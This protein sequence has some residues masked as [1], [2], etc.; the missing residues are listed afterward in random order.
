ML[1]VAISVLC[2]ELVKSTYPFNP[3]LAAVIARL[4]AL[5]CADCMVL[6]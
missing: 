5:T 2:T 6:A 1:A 4:A 3:M